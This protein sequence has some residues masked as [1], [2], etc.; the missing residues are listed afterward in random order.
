MVTGRNARRTPCPDEP[1][2]QAVERL[3]TEAQVRDAYHEYGGELL[4]FAANALEDHHLAE[5]VVQETFLRAWTSADRFDPALGTLRS[6]LFAIT[7]NGVVDAARRRA[8]ATLALLRHRDEEHTAVVAEPFDRLLVSMQLEEAM[9]RL[10]PDHSHIVVEV[11]YHGRTCADLA[12]E[13]VVPASTVRSRLYYGVRAL[14]LVLE[15]NG[16]LA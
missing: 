13:L 10:S 9:R 16:W 11:Y 3:H 7:R 15:E 1:G 8:T 12:R 14:R 5:E 4:G 2:G 6:W